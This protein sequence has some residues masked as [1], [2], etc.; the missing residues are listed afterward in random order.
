[1]NYQRCE[2]VTF[3]SPIAIDHRF[4]FDYEATR[5]THQDVRKWMEEIS[6]Q[7]DDFLPQFVQAF[8]KTSMLI[9]RMQYLEGVWEDFQPVEEKNIPYLRVLKRIPMPKSTYDHAKV[10]L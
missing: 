1:M 8:N 7:A 10:N 3:I 9:F 5:N 4:P 2:D 6:K